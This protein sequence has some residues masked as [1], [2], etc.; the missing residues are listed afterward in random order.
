MIEILADKKGGVLI[1][2]EKRLLRFLGQDHGE[3]EAEDGEHNETGPGKKLD[4]PELLAILRFMLKTLFH[5]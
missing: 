4:E 2:R 5:A 3:G 1:A